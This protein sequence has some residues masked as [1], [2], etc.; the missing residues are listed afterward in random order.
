MD[1]NSSRAVQA[2]RSW[3]EELK[4]KDRSTFDHCIR[5]GI[6]SYEFS[7][8]LQL[9]E[10]DCRRIARAGFAHDIGKCAIEQ[11]VLTKQNKLDNEQWELMKAHPQLGSDLLEKQTWVMDL[12]PVALQHHE[13]WDGQGYP[14]KLARHQI[15]PE[16]RLVSVVDAYDAMSHDRCY[17]HAKSHQAITQEIKKGS[18]TQFD[19]MLAESFLQLLQEKMKKE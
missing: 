14:N 6:L 10:E 13:R 9:P 11:A 17:R 19:P 8:W 3:L 16:A 18:G 1:I 12:A 5:V 4:E 15:M 2:L 7:S